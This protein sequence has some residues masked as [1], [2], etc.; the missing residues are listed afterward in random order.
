MI[1]TKEA[2]LLIRHYK[3]AK[4]IKPNQPVMIYLCREGTEEMLAVQAGTIGC[5]P[6]TGRLFLTAFVDPL[7][8]ARPMPDPSGN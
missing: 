5:D 3:Q 1:T 7:L 6:K 8:E 4:K 2:R